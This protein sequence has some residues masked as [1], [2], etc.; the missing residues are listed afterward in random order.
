MNLDISAVICTLN[1]EE[2]ISQCLS[3]LFKSGIFTVVV[4]D[5]GSTDNTLEKIDTSVVKVLRDPGRGLA[6]ARNIGIC[7]ISTE[8]VLIFGSDNLISRETINSMR[9]KLS[10]GY[11]GVSCR[12]TTLGGGYLSKAQDAMWKS[13]IK[14]GDKLY[15]GT[16]QLFNTKLLKD[17]LF[18]LSN[19]F[20]DDT[21]LCSRLVSKYGGVF[22]TV[23]D[24]CTEIGRSTF[25]EIRNRYRMYGISD[26]EIFQQNK[27]DWNTLR[28]IKSILHPLKVEFID[29]LFGMRIKKFVIYLP[30]ILFATY[31][32]YSSW[33]KQ[34]VR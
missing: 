29:S 7:E 20:S 18:S 25:R 21:E 10:Q 2:T 16:P 28:K 27:T 32:R 15:I 23:P 24:F 1:S 33:V 26:Y 3:S 6:L 8:N 9:H 11:L 5:G 19:R 12:T 34:I 17:N 31:L 30:V 13:K 14:S 4:V 22:H